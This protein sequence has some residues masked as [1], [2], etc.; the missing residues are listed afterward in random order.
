MSYCRDISE[1]KDESAA[2]HGTGRQ[3]LCVWRYST[4][5]NMVMSRES[6]RR[7]A[8]KTRETQRRIKELQEAAGSL[9]Q[10]RLR[11]SP[12]EILDEIDF[13]LS[14]TSL[15]GWQLFL[16]KIC[17]GDGVAVENLYST[18]TFEPLQNL[19]LG[20][21]RLSKTCF[22]QCSSW[23]EISS[24]P[25]DPPGKQKTVSSVRQ[26]LFK[27][28]NGIPAFIEEKYL[29]PGLY[30]ELAKKEQTA[31]LKDLLA[32]KELRGMMKGIN[33]YAVGTMF[34][35]AAAVIDRSLHSV[36]RWT[37]TWMRVLYTETVNKVFLDQRGGGW[38]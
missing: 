24:H 23:E 7:V 6:S 2:M 12:R 15:A 21:S 38:V 14:E 27:A 28:C 20:V 1:A 36:K 32:G 4:Y 18:V 37:L 29:V 34:P 8:A 13:L 33:Y 19:Q 25:E 22:I 9:A 5:E 30:V 26:P 10:G 31:H 3:N 17:G 16:E 11:A 35:F